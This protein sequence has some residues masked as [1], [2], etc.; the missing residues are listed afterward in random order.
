MELFE[1]KKSK[2]IETTTL[3][4]ADVVQVESYLVNNLRDYLSWNDK[5]PEHIKQVCVIVDALNKLKRL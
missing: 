5:D 3:T 4:R 1:H 2:T